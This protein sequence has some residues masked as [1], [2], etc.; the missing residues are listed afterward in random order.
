MSKFMKLF[1]TLLFILII[2]I[3]L[4]YIGHSRKTSSTTLGIANYNPKKGL[5][6]IVDVQDN[7]LSIFQENKLLKTYQIAGGKSS[8][9]SPIGVWRIINKDT[10]GK[11]FGGYWMGFNVPWG[12]YG[13]H[14]TTHPET[15][16]YNSS[17]GCIRMRN[18]DVAALYKITPHG[19]PVIIWGGPFGN[20]GSYLRTIKPGDRGADVYELQKIL[21]SKGY[22]RGNLDGIYGEGMKAIVHKYQ[23]DNKL[24]I[25]N[26]VNIRFYQALGV[27]VID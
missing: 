24:P 13:I 8:T 27:Y 18:E 19:T 21:S 1:L 4:I 9:P 2:E 23:K 17:Q 7:Y 20:F 15:I 16:G 5:I 26:D 10:W 3:I 12:Q 11:G 6:I 22:Y 25:N 14:G